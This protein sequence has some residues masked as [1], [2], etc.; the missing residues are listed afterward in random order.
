[1][2]GPRVAES[3]ANPS[4]YIIPPQVTLL[5]HTMASWILRLPFQPAHNIG[6]TLSSSIYHHHHPPHPYIFLFLLSLS[7]S[8]FPTLQVYLYTVQCFENQI[9]FVR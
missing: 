4:S 2:H 1:M 9:T 5:L 6:D 7:L 3:R 8:F